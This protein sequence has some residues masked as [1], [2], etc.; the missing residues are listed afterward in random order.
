LPQADKDYQYR[1]RRDAG[2]VVQELLTHTPVDFAFIDAVTSGQNSI[3][4]AR[5]CVLADYIGALK[6]GL[7]PMVSRLN[8]PSIKAHERSGTLLAQASI[9]GDLRPYPGWRNVHPLLRDAA[10]KRQKNPAI[11]RSLKPL[12]QKTDRSR[13]AF[14]NPVNEK[15]GDILAM[16]LGTPEAGPDFGSDFGDM[17][18]LAA[19]AFSSG[20]G[21]IAEASVIWNTLFDKDALM[22]REVPLNIDSGSLDRRAITTGNPVARHAAR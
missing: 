13:F 8:A 22:R 9:Q 15:L 6:M 3:I 7:D 19:L 17:H 16:L 21:Q 20:T 18:F 1:Y 5:D 2:L 4:A 14:K 11:D 10:R 12:S